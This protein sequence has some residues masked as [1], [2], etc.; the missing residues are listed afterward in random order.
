MTLFDLVEDDS[1]S[2][3]FTRESL[4]IRLISESL[5][6][7]RWQINNYD[8]YEDADRYHVDEVSFDPDFTRMEYRPPQTIDFSN[9]GDLNSNTS[10]YNDIPENNDYVH[11][12]SSSQAEI[13]RNNDSE[14]DQNDATQAWFPTAEENN[15]RSHNLQRNG[16]NRA[17]H[18]RHIQMRLVIEVTQLTEVKIILIS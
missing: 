4:H 18:V 10:A 5:Q 8:L 2:N 6:E 13:T 1:Y 7:E 12:A 14:D 15:E 9:H 11:T 16:P 3:Q 17:E